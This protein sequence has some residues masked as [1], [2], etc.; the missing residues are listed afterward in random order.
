MMQKKI[1]LII[2]IGMMLLWACSSWAQA[3]FSYEPLVP[4]PPQSVLIRTQNLQS[5]MNNRDIDT[6]VKYY[7]S[8]QS[9]KEI[10]RFYK[11]SLQDAGWKILAEY[12]EG[13]VTLITASENNNITVNIT[14]YDKE[15]EG[16]EIYVSLARAATNASTNV[17]YSQFAQLDPNQDAPGR[18][19][20]WAPRYPDAIRRM[21][22]EDKQSGQ[23]IVVYATRASVEQIVKFYSERMPNSGWYLKDNVKLEKIPGFGAGDYQNLVFEGWQGKCLVS[24]NRPHDLSKI[25]PQAKNTTSILL[26]FTPER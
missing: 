16:S 22:Q 7:L 26:N 20:N 3:D 19:P 6:E 8:P 10:F 17:A 4:A 11:R 9:S 15:A 23:V 5:V 2:I 24:V 12:N 25:A 18:D 21:Y 14:A 13:K 1:G